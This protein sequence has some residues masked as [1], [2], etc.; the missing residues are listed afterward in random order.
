MPLEALRPP[1]D[2]DTRVAHAIAKVDV[3][4]AYEAELVAA[5]KHCTSPF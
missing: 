1:Y 3:R 5:L 4:D 2:V